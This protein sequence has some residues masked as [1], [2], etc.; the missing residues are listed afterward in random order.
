[1]S[2]DAISSKVTW[3]SAVTM[4]LKT[5]EMIVESKPLPVK[6]AIQVRIGLLSVRPTALIWV[7]FATTAL[8][9]MT[10][11]LGLGEVGSCT[12]GRLLLLELG[13]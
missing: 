7:P 12:G 9:G 6:C 5:V 8:G 10:L 4:S 1:M 11:T 2:R 3:R 13:E